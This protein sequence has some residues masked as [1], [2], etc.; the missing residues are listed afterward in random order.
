MKGGWHRAH[1]ARCALVVVGFSCSL[2]GD[3]EKKVEEEKE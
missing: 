3:N 2:F 1:R